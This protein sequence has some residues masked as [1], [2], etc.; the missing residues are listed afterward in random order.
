MYRSLLSLSIFAALLLSGCAPSQREPGPSGPTR[1]R[2]AAVASTPE[3]ANAKG[4][5]RG[6]SG[7]DGTLLAGAHHIIFLGDSITYSG[8][9][10]DDLQM[11]LRNFPKGA[12]LEFLDLGLP[13]ETVSGLT[14]PGH[15]NGAFPRPN[16][17]DRLQRLLELTRP[18]LVIACYG[19]DD[20]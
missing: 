4:A 13:S 3:Q 6:T 10:I 18:D 14:E 20:G 17:H 15:A 1:A 11:A 9:Y 16:L 8:Q 19:M 7:L 12:E 5:A 2:S